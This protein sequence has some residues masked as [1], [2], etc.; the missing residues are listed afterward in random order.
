[1]ANDNKREQRS[2]DPARLRL[3]FRSRKALSPIF[4]TLIILAIVTAL[5]VP[6]FIWA[7][8]IGSQTQDSWRLSGLIATERIVIEEVSLVGGQTPQTCTIYVRTIGETAVTISDAIISLSDS[9]VHT[10]QKQPAVNSP[11]SLP[12]E[13]L[14]THDPT[15]G[16]NLQS[17]TKGNLI[18]I[19]ILNVACV[20]SG[21]TLTNHA[22]YT[23]KVFTT[24]GVSDST[25]VQVSW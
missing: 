11:P 7:T 13:Q 6:V 8:G 17:I 5:F 10:Y 16:Q 3:V 4:A 24:R 23:I 9:N 21:F 22:T 15:T 25:Q 14:S 19:R 20:D 1:M 2:F 12:Y 18:E